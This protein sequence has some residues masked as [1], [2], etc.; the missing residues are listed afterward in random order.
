MGVVPKSLSREEKIAQSSELRTKNSYFDNLEKMREVMRQ[1]P[2]GKNLRGDKVGAASSVDLRSVDGPAKDDGGSASSAA[3]LVNACD[4]LIRKTVLLNQTHSSFKRKTLWN[5]EGVAD[6]LC[7]K[8]MEDDIRH[9]ECV[10]SRLQSLVQNESKM[11][12]YLQKPPAACLR[13]DPRVHESAS[14]VLGDRALKTVLEVVEAAED[15]ERFVESGNN[16]DAETSAMMK[17]LS[18]H[19]DREKN[20]LAHL[21]TVVKKAVAISRTPAGMYGQ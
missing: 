7:P 1:N 5:R 15:V 10:I 18:D 8:K 13:L 9:L 6:A 12:V 17:Q 19:F 4:R 14:K 2:R 11:A 21:M 3:E 20:H 16:R